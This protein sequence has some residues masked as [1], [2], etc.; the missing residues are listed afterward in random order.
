MRIIARTDPGKVR[1]SNQDSYAAGEFR[2]GVAWAVVCDGM[3]GS[4]GGNVASS[5]A[6]RSISE[7]ITTAYRENMSSSSIRNLLVTAITNANYEIYDMT[8]A[9]PELA[10]MGTTVVAAI[11]DEENIYVA[12]AGDSRAY[13][14]GKQ[15]I[16]QLTRDHSV[17]QKMVENGEITEE[18][19]LRHPSKNLITRA[20]GVDENL[21]VDFT[22]E[23][24]GEKC[25]LLICTD[26]LTNYVSDEDIHKAILEGRH[27]DFASAL[28]DLANEHGGGDN[29]TVVAVEG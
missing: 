28:V 29:I 21:R 22:E 12:H 26:G 23:P 3:G 19:A 25:M 9:N 27:T 1:S 16:R 4:V 7:R 13:V 8:I 11:M 14:V 6:V 17:V 2:N 20:L 5:T 15:T 10:G 18:E 24:C